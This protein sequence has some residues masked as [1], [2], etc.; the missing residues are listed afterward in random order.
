MYTG[1]ES[2]GAV[3]MVTMRAY[4]DFM[5][6]L[7]IASFVQNTWIFT[8]PSSSV[9]GIADFP[10]NTSCWT[11]PLTQ[12]KELLSS[13]SSAISLLVGLNHIFRP[14]YLADL[15]LISENQ[16]NVIVSL[17]LQAFEARDIGNGNLYSCPSSSPISP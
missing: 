17:R 16:A 10:S 7:L 13:Q 6:G 14:L 12:S 2:P 15:Q 3:S 1:I 9:K 5:L 4:F 11:V 8:N